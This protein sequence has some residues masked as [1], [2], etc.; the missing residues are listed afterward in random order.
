MGKNKQ[1]KEC[2]NENGFVKN[3]LQFSGLIAC[4]ISVLSI[5]LNIVQYK[6]TK[7][8][9]VSSIAITNQTNI[10]NIQKDITDIN[11]SLSQI[12]ELS[13]AIAR[14]EGKLEAT[15]V[16]LNKEQIETLNICSE[17]K[18][19]IY[20]AAG[21]QWQEVSYIGTNEKTGEEYSAKELIGVKMLIPYEEDGQ[22]VLFLGQYNENMHW[23]GE[24][25]INVYDG[26]TLS[27]I[28][29]A[30]YDDGTLL[31]YK[32][33]MPTNNGTDGDTWSIS[34]RFI[35]DSTNSGE[36]I[37][38]YRNDNRTRTFDLKTVTESDVLSVDTFNVIY[39]N[40][41]MEGYYNGNTSKGLYNDDTG[42][43][44][45]IRFTK[46]GKVRTLYQGKVKNGHFNDDTG[47][48]WYIT[49][50]E[51][52]EYMYYKGIFKMDSVNKDL[53]DSE[54]ENPVTSEQ[55]NEIISNA[56]INCELIWQ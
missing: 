29:D 3:L 12:N 9:T 43:A 8:D 19:L 11:A 21:P 30:V 23:D 5:I 40:L 45:L 28:T 25:T 14:L 48:A 50:D 44:Y 4:G 51:N 1:K 33:V 15:T 56:D 6:N 53:P 52:T 20:V 16:A 2:L 55:I 47:N 34:E 37:C 18:N 31:S 42:N 10:T 41:V 32:Q 22:D 27:L 39:N 13:A 49:K 54:Y 38:Y 17:S 24:C 46:E 36:T 7:I 35:N 26:T